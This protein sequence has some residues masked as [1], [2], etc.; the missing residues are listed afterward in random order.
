[1]DSRWLVVIRWHGERAARPRVLIGGRRVGRGVFL[2]ACVPAGCCLISS[3]FFD[4]QYRTL[5]AP[6]KTMPDRE[7]GRFSCVRRAGAA[8]RDQYLGSRGGRRRRGRRSSRMPAARR[9]IGRAV[10]ARKVAAAA[11]CGFRGTAARLRA[12][13]S[14]RTPRARCCAARTCGV[15]RGLAVWRR[16]FAV[17]PYRHVADSTPAVRRACNMAAHRAQPGVAAEQRDTLDTPRA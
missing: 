13:S 8:A 12:C 16:G 17:S 5:V 6:A 4:R 10:A 3:L 11:S 14:R 15:I 9:S 7:I 1:M 2:V